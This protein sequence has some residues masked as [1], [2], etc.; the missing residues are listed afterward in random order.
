MGPQV[1]VYQRIYS[2]LEFCPSPLACVERAAR[3]GFAYISWKV[4]LGESKQGKQ[5]SGH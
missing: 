1:S 5:S 2:G 3:G 4:R